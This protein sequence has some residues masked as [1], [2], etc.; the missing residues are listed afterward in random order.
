MIWRGS[1]TNSGTA[2]IGGLLVVVAFLAWTTGRDS[3]LSLG[4]GVAG[5]VLLGISHL[6]VTLTAEDVLVRWGPWGFPRHRLPLAKIA[7]VHAVVIRPLHV[8]GWGY[9]GSRLLA[10]RA[11]AMVR[12]G[13][14]LRFELPKGRVFVVTVDDAPTGATRIQELIGAGPS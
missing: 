14:A 7:D 2:V 6:T 9:R 1:A 4:P 8:G 11:A 5:V 13:P 3:A 12:R 10:G